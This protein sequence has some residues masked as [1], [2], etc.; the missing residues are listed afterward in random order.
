MNM[1]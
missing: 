1:T